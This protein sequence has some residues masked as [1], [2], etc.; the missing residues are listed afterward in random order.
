[1]CAELEIIRPAPSRA[2]RQGRRRRLHQGATL[3]LPILPAGID[4][5][6]ADIE[7]TDQARCRSRPPT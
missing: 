2:A 3:D 7:V 1:M 4:L 5:S 6:D